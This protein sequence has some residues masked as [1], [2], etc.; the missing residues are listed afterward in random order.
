MPIWPVM[1]QTS[2]EPPRRVTPA[3]AR[4]KLLRSLV[5]KPDERMKASDREKLADLQISF[6][7]E[8]AEEP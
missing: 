2:E 6:L 4:A 7:R 5:A 8:L 1:E 3:E